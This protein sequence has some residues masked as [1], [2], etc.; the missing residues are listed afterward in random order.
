M[1]TLEIGDLATFRFCNLTGV[2]IKRHEIQKGR[3]TYDFQVPY[4][5][6]LDGIEITDYVRFRDIPG[7]HLL[8]TFKG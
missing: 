3:F 4:K 5:E 6:T 8:M 7:K 2:V 1:D